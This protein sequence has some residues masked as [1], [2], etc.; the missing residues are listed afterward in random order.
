MDIFLLVFL[1]IGGTL[2]MVSFL[3][4]VKDI[5][6]F[7]YTIFLLIFGAILYCLNAPLP[8]P[9]PVWP[10]ELSLRF[11]ELVIIISLMIAGL[12]IGLN[13]TWKEWKTPLR[14][15]VFTMPLYMGVI[16]SV[17]YF[18]LDFGGSISLLLASVLAPT[19]PALASEIQLNEKQSDAKKSVGVKFNLTAEAGLNDGLAFPFV[20]LAILWSS[21]ANFGFDTWMEWI[22]Y[23]VIYKI[24]VGTLIGIFIG[25]LYSWCTKNLSDERGK[26]IHHEFVAIALT[27]IA[28][29]IAEMANSYGFLSV[30]FAGLFAHYHMHTHNITM[31]SEPGLKFITNLEKVLIV[32]WIVFFG[33]SIMAGILNFISIPMIVFSIL[34]VLVIRPVLGYVSLFKTSL[35]RKKKM[36]VSFLGVRGIG[37]VF[38]LTYAFKNGSFGENYQLYSIVSLVILFSI[39]LHGVT[40]KRILIKI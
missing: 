20:Y 7:S 33:G 27:L 36:A 8:M 11:S 28:Y 3:P 16:F 37:S 5:F 4:I 13:Y 6:K 14:L 32:F 19:D 9:D 21:N 23:Y 18:L 10:V 40:A 25:F 29:S 17:S 30:F 39:I 24:V 12:K 35:T 31:H 1:I 38:Y 26:I 34:L 22:G 2:L 15:L